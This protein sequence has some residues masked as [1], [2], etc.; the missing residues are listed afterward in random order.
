MCEI[1]VFLGDNTN[2]DPTADR[3][4]CW[5]RGMPVV[6]RED[7]W[8]WGAS[9]G[10]P[11]FA[12]VKIPGV[13]AAQA[14]AFLD[15]Q[16]EDD[17]GVPYFET[18]PMANPARAIYRKRAWKVAIDAVPAAI[19]NQVLTTGSVTVTVAQIRN[20]LNRVRDGAIYAGMG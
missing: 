10:L 14:Q 11:T 6:V 15:A 1:L 18:I 8:P 19:R 17:A 2:A 4:G 9:E 13:A 7:G 16:L 20:F 3:K 12:I 5:K